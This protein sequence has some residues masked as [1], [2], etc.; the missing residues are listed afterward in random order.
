[1]QDSTEAFENIMRLILLQ[2]DNRRIEEQDIRFTL[3]YYNA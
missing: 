1:M 2:V 3:L